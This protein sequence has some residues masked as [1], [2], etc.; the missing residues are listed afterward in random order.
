MWIGAGK[1]GRGTK[2]RQA[3]IGVGDGADSAFAVDPA[4]R[5]AWATQIEVLKRAL[6]GR[7][8]AVPEHPEP[9]FASQRRGKVCKLIARQRQKEYNIAGARGRRPVPGLLLPRCLRPEAFSRGQSEA[10]GMG[11][12]KGPRPGFRL[13]AL[14]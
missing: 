5:D 7:P 8:G 3:S 9:N 13:E 1:P 12:T 14:T 2:Q 10:P 6:A 4:Q 11:K